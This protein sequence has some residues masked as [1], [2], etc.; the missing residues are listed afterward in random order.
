LAH[1]EWSSHK[2]GGKAGV[3]YVIGLLIHKPKLAW[4]E[5]YTK[6][7]K[8]NDFLRKLKPAIIAMQITGWKFIADGIYDAKPDYASI[9]NDFD[10]QDIK[11]FKKRVSSMHENFNGLL[12]KYAC[13]RRFPFLGAACWA[14]PEGHFDFNASATVCTVRCQLYC[15]I[16]WGILVV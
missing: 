13:P 14:H 15:I 1:S 3:N 2:L 7:G 16:L 4:V 5:G 6:L 11:H 8:E 12:K 10:P 9:K